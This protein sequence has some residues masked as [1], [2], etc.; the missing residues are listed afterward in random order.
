[1]SLR[2]RNSYFKV[3]IKSAIY[4]PL[5]P[6]SGVLLF[7]ILLKIVEKQTKDEMRYLTRHRTK[8]MLE[9]FDTQVPKTH[10]HI[11]IVTMYFLKSSSIKF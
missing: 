10:F 9:S 7:L 1:M 11:R 3:S 2:R 8:E 4:F 6:F 5:P